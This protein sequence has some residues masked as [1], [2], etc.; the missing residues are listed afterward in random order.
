MHPIW[1]FKIDNTVSICKGL[2]H[3]QLS[4]RW[5][6]HRTPAAEKVIRMLCRVKCFKGSLFNLGGLLLT[7]NVTPLL[8]KLW[9]DGD[10]RK[11]KGIAEVIII[12]II[13]LR[14]S[15][16]FVV[17]VFVCPWLSWPRVPSA[18]ASLPLCLSF[19]AGTGAASG[20]RNLWLTNAKFVKFPML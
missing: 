10:F 20:T 11:E 16:C 15:A 13:L 18:F 17:G 5:V 9:W 19:L 14:E 4:F 2:W 7:T 1:S 6:L 3:L 8:E 12:I